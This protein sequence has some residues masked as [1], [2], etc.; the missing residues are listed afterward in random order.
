MVVQRVVFTT[1]LVATVGRLASF[2]LFTPQ[3]NFKD[4]QLIA[5]SLSYVP[6]P[7]TTGYILQAVHLT[8]HLTG[9]G[10]HLYLF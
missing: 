6:I 9:I 5:P 3:C 1:Y 4:T 8:G 10:K 7:H 2:L